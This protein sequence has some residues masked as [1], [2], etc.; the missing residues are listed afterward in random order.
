MGLHGTVIDGTDIGKDERMEELTA[1]EI[2]A[3]GRKRRVKEV[4]YMGRKVYAHGL[5]RQEAKAYWSECQKAGGPG[6]EDAY[7]D[8]RLIVWC[9][10]DS[11]GRPVFK[12]DHILQIA[13]MNEAD[14]RPLWSACMEV[15][16]FGATGE[17]AAR[18]NSETTPSG[19]SGSGSPVT[20]GSA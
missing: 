5:S 10:R 11:A 4:S 19:D 3:N 18:K 13:D 9:L 16:G 12:T 17:A 1:Q 6:G 2:I 7:S 8:E 20:T 14:F 15:N